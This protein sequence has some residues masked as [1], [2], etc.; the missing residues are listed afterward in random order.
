MTPQQFELVRS[1]WKMVVPI[2]EQAAEMFYARLF[3]LDPSL[4]PLFKGDMKEQGRKLMAMLG[5]VVGKLDALG[6]LVPAVKDLGAR[7]GDYG[8]TPDH[9]S[10]VASALLWTLDEGLGDAF[11]PEAEAAWTVAY[12]TLA[13]VMIQASGQRN[14]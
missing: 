9:Y 10:T 6:E 13:G 14:D 1:T 3:E 5:M 12:T 8:V 2:K 11:T 7:H 4:R